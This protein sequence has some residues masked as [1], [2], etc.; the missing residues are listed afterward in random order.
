MLLPSHLLCF[1]FFFFALLFFLQGFS[2]LVLSR[3]PLDPTVPPTVNGSPATISQPTTVKAA[4]AES[5]SSTA[6]IVPLAVALAVVFVALLLG[7]IY[8]R[9]QRRRHARFS[10]ELPTSS[11]SS[12]RG[13]KEDSQDILPVIREALN[14]LGFA[15]CVIPTEVKASSIK[16]LSQ[17]GAGKFG[18]VHKAFMDDTSRGTCRQ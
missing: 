6:P 8:I 9:K 10:T 7:L 16:I 5:T 12:A 14:R 2:V 18:I 3:I 15:A 4:A 17:L 13:S 1:S 11:I